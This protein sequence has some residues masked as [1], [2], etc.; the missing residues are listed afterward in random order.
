MKTLILAAALLLQATGATVPQTAPQT[1]APNA[2]SQAGTADRPIV[3]EQTEIDRQVMALS[4]QLRCPVCQGLS[5]ADS[6]SELSQEMRGVVRSLLE[7]GK[8]PEEVKAYFVSKYGEWILLEPEPTGFN[9]A[10]YLLPILALLG[11][12]VLVV[13][14]VKR[15]SVQN[16]P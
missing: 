7:E 6:P 11:G 15:W 9:M 12:A 1:A 16:G 4:A 14:L 8:S 2:A 10:V 5:L 13:V 3:I